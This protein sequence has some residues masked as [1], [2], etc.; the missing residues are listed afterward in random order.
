M[1]LPV[2]MEKQYVTEVKKGPGGNK[3]EKLLSNYDKMV[4][5]DTVKRMI[6]KGMDI[7]TIAEVTNLSE[8][9]VKEIAKRPTKEAA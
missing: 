3:M 5:I 6:N 4:I 2:D 9:E 8:Y 1:P 7:K